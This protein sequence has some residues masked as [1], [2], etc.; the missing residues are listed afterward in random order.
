LVKTIRAL[1]LWIKHESLIKNLDNGLIISELTYSQS[2]VND[3]FDVYCGD[4]DFQN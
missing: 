1:G 4:F 2:E 3:R